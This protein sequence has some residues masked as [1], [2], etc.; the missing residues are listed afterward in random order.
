MPDCPGQWPTTKSQSMAL[1]NFA[2]RCN[3]VKLG[4]R[5]NDWP[6]TGMTQCRA[7]RGAK[8]GILGRL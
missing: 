5:R 2:P 1:N 7:A 4:N 8:D 3:I 6:R